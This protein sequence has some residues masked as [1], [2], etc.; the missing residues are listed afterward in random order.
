MKKY[1]NFGLLVLALLFALPQL[2][3]WVK[4]VIILPS[5]SM[6]V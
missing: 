2:H 5:A 1:K 3:S 6:V 4:N